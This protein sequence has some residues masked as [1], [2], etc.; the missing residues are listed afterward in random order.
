M[1]M[2]AMFDHQ[3][4]FLLDVLVRP[5]VPDPYIRVCNARTRIT[6]K[7]RKTGTN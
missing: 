3:L 5:P 4:R 6:Y 1:I 2:Q 7:N